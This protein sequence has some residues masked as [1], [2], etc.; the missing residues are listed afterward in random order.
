VKN[1]AN[2]DG[3]YTSARAPKGGPTRPVTLQNGVYAVRYLFN[4]SR[5]RRRLL[6]FYDAVVVFSSAI[7][8]PVPGRFEQGCVFKNIVNIGFDGAAI[9]LPEQGLDVHNLARIIDVNL[10]NETGF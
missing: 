1:D 10:N 6:V 8:P 2:N 4:E 7:W 9:E 3:H 5:D